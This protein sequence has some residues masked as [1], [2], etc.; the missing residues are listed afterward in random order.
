MEKDKIIVVSGLPR[1][2]T[3][4]MMQILQSIGM[5]LYTDNKRKSDS[6][7]PKGYF[8]HEKVKSIDK[9]SSWLTNVKGKAVKIISPLLRNLPDTYYY[10][11]VLMYREI[12]EIIKSQQKMLVENNTLNSEIDHEN[13]KKIFV[14]DIKE[15]KRWIKEK[16]NCQFLEISYNDIVKNPETEIIKIKQFVEI[17]SDINKAVWIVDKN[18]YR[19]K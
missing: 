3:S 8:E 17:E 5:Q 16:S 7:N 19:V 14:K 18:L 6:S 15:T 10:K 12:D 11:I 4:L 1:S 9:D 13:L 2:G